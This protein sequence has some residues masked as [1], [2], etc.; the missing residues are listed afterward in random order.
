M[1]SMS[2]DENFVAEG[3]SPNKKYPSVTIAAGAQW[4]EVYAFAHE[5]GY[6]VVGGDANSVGAAGGWPLGG[7]HSY[8]S[9]TYGLGVDNILEVRESV[10]S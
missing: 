5:H 4:G 10:R 2:F 7:G 3:C 1:K 9:P 8:L 6:M